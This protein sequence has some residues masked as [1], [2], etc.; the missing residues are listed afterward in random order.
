MKEPYFPLFM[1]LSGQ[2][3]VTVG[4]GR[5]ALRRIKTLLPFG[6][7]I[8]VIAPRLCGEL[9]KICRER[10]DAVQVLRRTYRPEDVKNADLVLA[11]TDSREVNR[12]IGQ[13]CRE[14]GILVNVADDHTLCDFYFPSVVMT[15]D[16]VIGISSGGASPG[17]TKQMRRDIENLLKTSEELHKLYD[18]EIV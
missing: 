18:N 2:K 14:K 17:K 4:G 8:C 12:M 11:A 1:N 7:E 10:A 6:A 15:E 5:I 13:E 16:T 9:E 3:I